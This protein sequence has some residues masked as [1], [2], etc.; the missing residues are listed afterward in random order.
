MVLFG[1][2]LGRRHHDRL[3]AGLDRAQHRPERD[4][5]FAAADVADEDAIHLARRGEVGA[6]LFES[7]ALRA[8]HLKRNRLDEFF[9]E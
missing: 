4:R 8:G 9:S 2:Q 1:E 6:N 5:G 7:A 3:R